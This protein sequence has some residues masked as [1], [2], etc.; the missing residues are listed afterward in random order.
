MQT[1]DAAE[2]MNF[3]S[4]Y[5]PTF[6]ERVAKRLGFNFRLGEEPDGVDAYPGWARTELRLDFSL[7]DR[8]RLLVTGRLRVSLTHYTDKQFDTMKTRTDLRFPA[9]WSE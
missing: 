1:S 8:L 2:T 5:R 7:M 3:A 4:I 9:P 6:A